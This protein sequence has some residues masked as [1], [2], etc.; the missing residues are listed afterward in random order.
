MQIDCEFIAL[1]GEYEILISIFE[2]YDLCF[3]LIKS[4]PIARLY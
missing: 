2:S 4:F 1:S 3:V